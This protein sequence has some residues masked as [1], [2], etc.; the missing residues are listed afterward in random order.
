MNEP[1]VGAPPPTVIVLAGPNGA[2]KTTAAPRLLRDAL[3]LVEFVNADTIARGLAGF[4]PDLAAIEAGTIMFD[5]I[6]RLASLRRN[7]AFE[8]TLAS[9]SLAPWIAELSQSGYAFNLVFPLA[10][11]R[12]SGGPARGGPS[13]IGRTQRARSHHSA[14]LRA[15]AA[16]F[17]P[18]LSAYGHG[19]AAVR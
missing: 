8:T 13:A 18:S 5:R 2:G 9:R 7:F 1:H 12:R 14:P 19:M 11:Q 10:A 17:L 6:R 4:D 3:G 15:R 16:Q